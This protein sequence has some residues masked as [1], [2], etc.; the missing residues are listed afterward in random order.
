MIALIGLGNPGEKHSLNRHNIGFI[1]IDELID[2][3]EIIKNE[4]KFNGNL[5]TFSIGRKKIV[6]FKSCDY[7]NECGGSLS[8]IH[9]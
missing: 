4:K 3:N 6:T 1:I 2:K 5:T 7:M 9:I 8:L